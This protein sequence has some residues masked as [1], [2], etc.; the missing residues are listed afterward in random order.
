MH[1]VS[2]IVPNFNHCDYFEER[3]NSI[4]KQTY[5]DYEIIILD[6]F[7]TDQSKEII[8]LY[9]NNINV[10]HV[11]Y[12][13]EN[14]GS[15]FRQWQKGIS[16]AKGEYIWIAESDDVSDLF[17]L[18]KVVKNISISENLVLSYCATINIDDKD[19]II[20]ENNWASELDPILWKND[21]TTDEKNKIYPY[22]SFRNIIP[23]A[24]AVLFKKSAINDFD[25][26][27]IN[28]LKYTGDWMFWIHIFSKGEIAFNSEFLN[29]QRHHSASTTSKKSLSNEIIRI[30]EYLLCIKYYNKLYKLSTSF[31]DKRYDWIFDQ[32]KS[33]ISFNIRT[34]VAFSAFSNSFSFSSRLLITYFK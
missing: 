31:F 5:I 7:S 33:N 8:E 10:S 20:G 21:F 26:N 11:V 12:N 6:D 4:L 34:I 15:P 9:R 13:T 17:F 2:V 18:Q 1:S 32:I 27:K 30:K 14:S 25:F 24:S 29:F 19:G 16:L 28:K 3:I 23:N 22:L